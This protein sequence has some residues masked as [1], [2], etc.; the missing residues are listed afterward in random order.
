MTRPG[1][2][3][4]ARTGTATLVRPTHG[5]KPVAADPAFECDFARYLRDSLD[6]PAL[7]ALYDRFADG[8]GTFDLTMRRIVWRALGVTL[9]DS[10][11]IGRGVRL[12]DAATC[13]IGSGVVIGDGAVLQGRHDGVCRIGDRVWIGPQAFIDGR[14]LVIEDDVGVG[15]GVRIIGSQHTGLPAHLPVV[16]TDLDTRPIRIEAGADIGAAAVILPGVT[17]G[18]GAIVGAGAV[19]SRDVPAGAVAAGVPARSRRQRKVRT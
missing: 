9:G 19:V 7:A 17:I 4:V 6:M 16:A 3:G 11:V 2:I 18:R 5:L 13:T 10:V 12:R 15:P 8:A 14:D 1:R